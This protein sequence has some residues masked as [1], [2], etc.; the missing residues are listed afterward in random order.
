MILLWAV[1]G[2]SAASVI[3]QAATA[4]HHHRV[5]NH[6]VTAAQ[7]IAVHGY[8]RS[9][10]LHGVVACGY[11]TAISLQA[12]GVRLPGH[13]LSAESLLAFAATQAAGLASSALD[14]GLRHRLA[15]VPGKTSAGA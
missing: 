15:G 14:L 7:R 3:L 9:A 10:G 12:A 13:G 11:L 6:A 5:Q 2:V 8:A 1:L 4:A